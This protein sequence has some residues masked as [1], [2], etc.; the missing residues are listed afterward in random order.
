MKRLIALIAILIISTSA[1]G[2]SPVAGREYRLINP[3]QPVSG[4]QIEVLE[5]FSYAC[6]HCDEF[7]PLLNSWLASKPKG[8]NFSHVPAVFNKRMI[9]HAQLYYTLEETGTLSR[10]H[11]K[12]YDAIHRQGKKLADR[13]AIMAWAATQ[14][15]DVKKFEAVFD[16][17]SVGNKTQRAIQLTRNF[18][19]PG[20][21]YLV[22]N[23]KY[24]TGPGMTLSP[25]GGGV[26]AQ[27]FVYVL[28]SLIEMER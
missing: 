8:V 14:D 18:R 19:V 9:P 25:S 24:L 17:F 28:N 5:F 15:V 21:P 12:V 4:S 3:P 6:P 13:G 26:D 22:V 27:R 16:S 7:E 10:L 20:T 23:G 2:Q 11:G 1:L